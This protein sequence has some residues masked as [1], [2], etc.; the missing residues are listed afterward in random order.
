ME[1]KRSKQKAYFFQTVEKVQQK[2]GFLSYVWYNIYG[3]KNVGRE[4]KF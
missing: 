1:K 2:L 4:K 3:D